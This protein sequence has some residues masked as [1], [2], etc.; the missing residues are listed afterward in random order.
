MGAGNPPPALTGRDPQ[1]QQWD[2]LV[3]R[4]AAGRSDQSP[5]VS[6]LRGVGKTVLQTGRVAAKMGYRRASSSSV[7]RDSLIKKGLI[8]SPEH[9]SV[10][11]TVPQFAAFMRRR[12]P[13][14]G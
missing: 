3:R 10:D 9:G 5:I 13:F 11:F 7:P 12:Y 4:L 8:Y 2:V 1:L 14:E 6:G